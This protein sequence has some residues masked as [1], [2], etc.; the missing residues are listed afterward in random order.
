MPV[1]KELADKESQEITVIQAYLP[2][3]LTTDEISA[4]VDQAL[5]Q[6]RAQAMADMGKVMAILK[7][8][9]QGRADMGEVSKLV[10][11]KLA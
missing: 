5:Q 6:S 11:S 4:L 7:P 10:K 1:A 8:Q 2:Q 9:L 3:Q